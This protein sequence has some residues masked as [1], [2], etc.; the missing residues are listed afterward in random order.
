MKSR[1]T[2]TPDIAAAARRLL[3]F[4]S[5][6]PGQQ[7]AIASLIE[8]CDT[9][10]VQPTGS[11]KSAIYQ[12]AG[13]LLPGPTLVV[14]PLIALQKDQADAIE[15]S[16]LEQTAV[17]NSTLTIAEQRDTLE[18][19]DQGAAKYIFLAP[20]QLSRAETLE[21]LQS[22]GISLVAIDE[23][24]CVSQWGH[25]FRPDYLQLARV[26]EALG[27]P[28]TIAMTATASPEVRAE[29]V[30]RLGL[31]SP[32]IFVRGFDRPN[33]SLRV[34]TFPN[35]D[36]KCEALLRRI[37]FADKPGIVYVSTHKAAESIA[38][39]LLHRGV[40]AV[41]YHGGLKPKE[42]EAIQ[43]RFMAGDVPVMVATNAFG[44][45][46]DKPDIRFVYHADVSDS[47]DAYYQEIGRAGRD[48]QPA[49]AVLFFCSRDI[50]AQQFKTAGGVNTEELD[51]LAA[52]LADHD[53]P[54]TPDELA[55]ATGLSKRKLINLVHK[56]EEAA[57]ATQLD[58]GAIEL[59]PGHSAAQ[60][61]ARVTQLQ[62][63]F[64]D[65]RKRRLEQMREYSEGR[66]CRR[67]VLLQYFGEETTGPCGNCDRCEAN[68][69][70][71]AAA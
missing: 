47:L 8:G 10:V 56:L 12:I 24:H 4:R 41:F 52:A 34:D 6:R 64:N 19:I 43:N 1:K 16:K 15:A 30:D 71:A 39:D 13:A 44:M 3:G 37:E 5:L 50:G 7:D 55:A 31:R 57:A 67:Q 18:R 70:V 46:V 38:S 23:A 54:A 17:V 22:A 9:L 29:I 21:H 58:S 2:K 66:A 32:R 63:L 61:V 51:S 14:S 62:Q 33:I 11:G 28:P 35:T 65:M 20:E 59:L 69:S 27:H 45:G 48:G 26:I 42:R 40:E 36:Q 49:E 53:G 60:I 25:D 68:R